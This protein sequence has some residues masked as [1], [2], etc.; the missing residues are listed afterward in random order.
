MLIV[1]ADDKESN[2]ITSSSVSLPSKIMSETKVDLEG[3]NTN[4]DN[5][6]NQFKTIIPK[7]S[8]S[9]IKE[10]AISEKDEKEEV[11]QQSS[12]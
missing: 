7:N 6:S 8:R 4:L 11:D 5:I 1:P 3:R 9:G 10:T 12:R 2:Y